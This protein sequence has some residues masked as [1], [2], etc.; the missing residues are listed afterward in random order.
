MCLEK[1]YKIYDKYSKY[2]YVE[3]DLSK[4]HIKNAFEFDKDKYGICWDFMRA[5]SLSL[6]KASYI[7]HC[8]FTEVQKDNKMIASHTYIIVRDFQFNYW[9][10]CAWQKHKGVNF[11]FSY[12]DVERLLK[13]EYDADETHTVVYSPTKTERMTA[14]EFFKYLNKEGIELP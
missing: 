12:K 6:H 14:D 2:D 11:V 4:H 1:I 9:I 7:H 3:D 5:M 10:E 8:Y 13:E